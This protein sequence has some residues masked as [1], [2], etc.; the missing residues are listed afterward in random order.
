MALVS[1]I[2]AIIAELDD[3]LLEAATE[4]GERV[5]EGARERVPVDTGSLRDAI[6]V[7]ADSEGVRVIAGDSDAFYGHI[8]EHGGAKTPAQPFLTPAFEVEREH[9]DDVVREHMKDL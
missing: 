1:R 2:P 5:A 7:E 9:L 6:H 8:V 4:I 3:R